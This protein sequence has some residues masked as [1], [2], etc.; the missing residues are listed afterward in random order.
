[1]QNE[2]TTIHIETSNYRCSQSSKIF[3]LLT[4]PTI[5]FVAV[6]MCYLNYLSLKIEIH[7]VILI[8][9]IYLIYLFFIKNN[10]YYASCKFRNQKQDLILSLQDYVEKN[11]LTLG[12]TTKANGDVDSFLEDYTNNL[13]NTNFSSI[14]SAVFPTLGILGTFISIAFSMP[15]FNSGNTTALE[16][17]ISKLLGGVGT[18][19]YVSIYGIFLSLWWTFFEKIGMSRFEHDI[20]T[21]KEDTKSHFW[22]K[23]DIETIHVKNNLD[24]FAKMNE[25]FEK[26]SSN[27][28]VENINSLIEQRVS[29]L[30]DILKKELELSTRISDNVENNQELANTIKTMTSHVNK[31][32]QLFENQREIFG[33][34][35]EKLNSSIETLNNSLQHLSSE[36]V[37]NLYTEI[38]KGVENMKSEVTFIGSKLET[39][40]ENYDSKFTEKLKNSLELIDEQTAKIVEDLAQ[41]NQ[42]SK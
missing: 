26:L 28:Y 29:L 35:S 10:A 13:R 17:E 2:S 36:N 1:M 38:L 32:V 24:S 40:I 3:M 8:G 14:A 19:F 33:K 5:L 7:S 22:T 20:Y 9:F 11:L 23:I 15:D 6:L 4:I 16:S 42:S 31:N 12:N 39:Q 25:L 37:K 41:L 34:T 27:N 30:E 21:I 18:A